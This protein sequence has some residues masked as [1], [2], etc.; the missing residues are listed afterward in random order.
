MAKQAASAQ[1]LA[2]LLVKQKNGTLPEEIGYLD[3]AE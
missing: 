2:T 3:L 1:V